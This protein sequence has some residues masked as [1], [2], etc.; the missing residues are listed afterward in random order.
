MTVECD[1]SGNVFEFTN[2]LDGHGGAVVS[3]DCSDVSWTNDFSLLTDDCGSTGS[4]VVTFTATDACGNSITT[5]GVFTI[6]DTT[7][8]AI[9][10]AAQ[11]TTIDCT[12]SSPALI[13]QQWLDAHGGALAYEPCGEVSWSNNLIEI[14]DSCDLSYQMPVV[15]TA[16]DA[17]GNASATG[18]V[19]TLTGT[20]DLK[21][22][23]DPSLMFDVVPN[24]ASDLICLRFSTAATTDLV[25][26]LYDVVG[27][28]L[29]EDLLTTREPCM[30]ISIFASGVYLLQ[31]SMGQ[32]TYTRKVLIR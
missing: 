10:R 32:Q 26:S 8:P 17:C 29:L 24:P 5:T 14:P 1:G 30:D 13:V 25:I 22:S 6:L 21:N 23:G 7:A 18:A 20:V 16:M 2:W 28:C 11:D 9:T 3:D 27:R 31:I 19:L 12:G 4:A 15:F